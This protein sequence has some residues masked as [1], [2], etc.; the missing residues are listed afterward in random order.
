MTTMTAAKP[1][2]LAW[3]RDAKFGMFIHWGLYALPGGIW[4]GQETPGIGEWLMGHFKIPLQ[5]Y[6][7]LADELNPANFDAEAIARLAKD[8]GM[9]YLVFTAKHHDGFALFDSP[10]DPYN[11]VKATPWGRDPV[12]ELAE[13]CAKEGVVFC[14][15]YSQDLDWAHP[16]G[17]GN[18]W[19]FPAE[20]KVFGRY[21]EEKCKPQLREL[22][23]NYGPV[24]LVWF[25]MA[26]N[27][28]MEQSRDIGQ[29]VHALQPDCLVSGRVGH[30]MGDYGSLGDNQIPI[31]RLKGDWEVPATLNHTWGFKRNDHHWKGAGQI[32]LNLVDIA[33]KGANY[34]LNIGPD[35]TGAVPEPSVKTLR[36]TGHWLDT[37]GPAIYGTSPSPFPCE[38]DWG[39]LTCAEGRLNLI[40]TSPRQ[41]TFTLPGIRS[42]IT[43]AYALHA[44]A[45]P[46]SVAQS[47]DHCLELELPP[48]PAD[49]LPFV[50][51][52]E[53]EGAL[54]VDT[55]ITEQMGGVVRLFA[56]MAELRLSGNA[57]W[58]RDV[59]YAGA[60]AA[61]AAEA[62]NESV[63]DGS[64]CVD[65]GGL[66]R[67][68]FDTEDY[69]SW[70][71]L[72]RSPG[73]FRLSVQTVAPKYQKWAG[74]HRL[75]VNCAGQRL[76]ALVVPGR[77]VESHRSG[78]FE[79][80]ATDLGVV[81]FERPGRYALELKALKIN[82]EIPNG[83]CVSEL[84]LESMAS[85]T[86]SA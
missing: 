65:P 76:E 67:N 73:D 36:E 63:K 60:L 59:S 79:E 51:V 5:E 11:I 7:R 1:G 69:L 22:L 26:T 34:L 49:G 18:T 25:D 85:A 13:A 3:W 23:A 70:D 44:P 66:V 28:T 83:L 20:G 77:M 38:F 54:E 47:S 52:C 64:L 56:H 46:V 78:H 40:F 43:S 27:I 50:V 71:F 35:A 30:G 19:D 62:A 21:L 74:G 17:G 8:A 61:A 55:T 68:W 33:A 29:L 12:R 80:A 42:T 31:G 32:V 4:K 16:D 48:P 75:A 6:R 84:R 86:R 39:R 72:V 57:P 15:Y 14:L 9:K 53:F 41:G 37:N 24:G 58:R 2:R 45:S 81:H 10:C 82:P